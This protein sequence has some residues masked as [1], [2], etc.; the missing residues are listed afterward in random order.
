MTAGTKVIKSVKRSANLNALGESFI[1]LGIKT[2]PTL[3]YASQSGSTVHTER[4]GEGL[5]NV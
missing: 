1:P 4:I 5:T 2:H 3:P